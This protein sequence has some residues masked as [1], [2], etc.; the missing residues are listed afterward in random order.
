MVTGVEFH[1]EFKKRIFRKIRHSFRANFWDS[2]KWHCEILIFRA[3][4]CHGRIPR[5]KLMQKTYNCWHFIYNLA[6]QLEKRRKKTNFFHP[7]KKRKKVWKWF[8]TTRN[9]EIRSFE[10]VLRDSGCEIFRKREKFH[11]WCST[12]RYSNGHNCSREHPIWLKIFLWHAYVTGINTLS[13]KFLGPPPPY[14]E[15]LWPKNCENPVYNFVCKNH[16]HFVFVKTWSNYTPKWR[17][18]WEESHPLW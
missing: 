15:E 11:F 4:E 2:K 7:T 14:P 13:E 8:K 18:R 3:R 17:T 9:D 12:F 16:V 6:L 1:E 5:K 10:R